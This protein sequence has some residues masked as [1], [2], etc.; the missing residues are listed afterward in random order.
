MD[1][2]ANLNRPVLVLGG[3]RG[4]FKAPASVDS[5]GIRL[6]VV[7]RA[8]KDDSL[9]LRLVEIRGR[10]SAGTLHFATKPSRV[11]AT[12]LVEWENGP[13]L[14]LRGNAIALELAPF[15]ILT[16]RVEGSGRSLREKPAKT[17]RRA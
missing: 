14:P 4:S 9:I 17:P 5:D 6:E 13:A 15:E 12:D 1:E 3:L 16:L 2:A 8:E 10:H 11:S 7:K